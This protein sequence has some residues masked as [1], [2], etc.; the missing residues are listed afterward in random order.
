MDDS[1]GKREA[2]GLWWFEL[3]RASPP[4]DAAPPARRFV[5]P[6]AG[7]WVLVRVAEIAA[8]EPT[9]EGGKGCRLHM[10]SGQRFDVQQV[11]RDI[12]DAIAEREVAPGEEDLRELVIETETP[13]AKDR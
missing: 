1:R 11:E 10:R 13:E 5:D 6:R 8:V 4:P 7:L 9:P 2:P 3:S 12:A